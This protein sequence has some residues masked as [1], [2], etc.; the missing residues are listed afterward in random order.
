MSALEIGAEIRITVEFTCIDHNLAGND[1]K[2]ERTIRVGDTGTIVDNCDG[3]YQVRITSGEYAGFITDVSLDGCEYT[4]R[5]II[6]EWIAY[7]F[8]DVEYEFDALTER[9]QAIFGTAE[10]FDAFIDTFSHTAE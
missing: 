1:G 8:N 5:A 3:L 2:V 6:S 9:E 4:D 10:R 7:A